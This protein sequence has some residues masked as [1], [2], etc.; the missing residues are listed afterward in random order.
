M[1]RKACTEPQYLHNGAL[2]LL[3]FY[4]SF[5]FLLEELS[6]RVFKTEMRKFAHCYFKKFILSKKK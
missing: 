4:E 1:G 6:F 5:T 3:P 2:Y